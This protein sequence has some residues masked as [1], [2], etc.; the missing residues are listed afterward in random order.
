[1]RHDPVP[2]GQDGAERVRGAVA[3]SE[4]LPNGLPLD[5]PGQ[6]TREPDNARNAAASVWP[7]LKVLLAVHGRS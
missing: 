6:P 3:G 7:K 2:D 5:L 4:S 1:M